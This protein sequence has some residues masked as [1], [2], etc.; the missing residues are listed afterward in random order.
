MKRLS[1]LIS[2]R[3]PLLAAI[4]ASLLVGCAPAALMIPPPRL[5]KP[6]PVVD[7]RETLDGVAAA[8][9]S[10]SEELGEA[11]VERLVMPERKVNLTPRVDPTKRLRTDDQ[12]TVTVDAIP[13]RDF[14]NYVFGELMK[15]SFVVTDGDNAVYTQPITLSTPTPVSSQQMFRLVAEAVGARGVQ[16]TE[17]DS[18][19]FVS[20]AD[21]KTSG[22]MPIGFGR[23]A[24]DVPDDPGKV[25]QVIPLRFGFN[26]TLD[27]TVR[28]MVNVE[29][30]N[31]KD[32][33]ALFVTGTRQAIL[34]VIDIVELFDQPSVRAS[35]V[36]LINL[37][38]VGS[39]EFTDQVTTLL[40]NE[41]VPAGV[42]RASEK[43][44][45]FV[46]LDRLGAVAVFTTSNELLSRVEFW[47]RHVDQPS[48]G[49]TE[50]YFIY[51]PKYARA[52]DL[53]ESLAPLIGAAGDVAASP[54]GNQS[55]DT[56]SAVRSGADAVG[57]REVVSQ[58]G[59]EQRAVSIKG[60]GLTISVDPRSNSLVFFT[61]GLRYE[62]LLPMIRRL[63]VPPKQ[64]LLEA[65]IA[66]VNLSG[67]FAYGVEFAFS[68]LS[69]GQMDGS[70]VGATPRTVEGGTLGGL[71]LPS[72]GLGLTYIRTLTDQV[73]L[74][75]SAQDTRINVLSNPVLVVRD[76][77]DATISVGNDVPTVGSTVSD[78]LQ[79]NRTVTTVLYRRTG[80]D[81]R[82]RPTV[83]AQGSVLM[84]IDQRIS[85][86]VPGSSGVNGAPVFF[87]RNVRTEV[88]AMSGQS[89]LLA[90]L[91]S[92]S[93]SK[94][95]SNVPV[96]SRIPG[97]G[98][99]FRSDSKRR[100]KTELILLITPRVIDDPN[101]WDSLRGGLEEALEFVR[102]P[103][104]QPSAAALDQ[105]A[106]DLSSEKAAKRDF[107]S[108]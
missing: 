87:D 47:S 45:A 48:R 77:M 85:S 25:L 108:E 38:Y 33:N 18:V 80:L 43:N 17:R 46:P 30:V 83:N 79:S 26:P 42:G 23:K 75:L 32:Q 104:Q 16:I 44:V 41:G 40:E 56:R 84:E 102:F 22:S 91:I 15:M 103:P 97:V 95:S 31:D 82:I 12:L 6:E 53:G 50:R 11:P 9:A 59:A 66:E 68:R 35:Y 88:V 34:R 60:D 63:D 13:M 64:V 1:Y 54:A 29:I 24:E 55:R 70:E 106:A 7:S 58:S 81:L 28:S 96:L 78:P 27:R 52:S 98:A 107:K 90:G 61:T 8:A 101:E 57:R 2:A 74:R 94:S 69:G 21:P 19:F 71:G 20:A 5:A 10:P 51:Q 62:S 49:P 65:T 72:G 86:T 99:L 73:R 14:L 4:V 92:D 100:E 39:R 3:I 105:G 93:D 89:V 67:E 36:A 76:G 37:T